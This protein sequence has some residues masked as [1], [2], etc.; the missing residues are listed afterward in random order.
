MRSRPADVLRHHS[1]LGHHLGQL[2]HYA[3]TVSMMHY[4]ILVSM[5][6]YVCTLYTSWALSRSFVQVHIHAVRSTAYTPR[7][8]DL[9]LTGWHHHYR[10][11]ARWY[12]YIPQGHTVHLPTWYIIASLLAS[13]FSVGT[14][15]LQADIC[16]GRS[17]SC[18]L[19]PTH[20]LW[21]PLYYASPTPP[22]PTIHQ[23]SGGKPT[24]PPPFPGY[25]IH[26][27]L[28]GKPTT[29]GVHRTSA[30]WYL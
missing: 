2:V 20:P 4:A 12:T 18:L 16:T 6:C 9:T 21:Y 1:H 7:V 22:V 26:Q 5:M 15:Q 19:V 10:H 29:P 28:G 13:S 25:T 11:P 30:E 17:I 3:I 23:Q 24:T 14:S 8:V 27:K